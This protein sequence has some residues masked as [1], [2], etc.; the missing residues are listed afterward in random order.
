MCFWWYMLI[1]DLI[2]P[3]VMIISGRMMW[4]HCPNGS[5]YYFD[6]LD[7]SNRKS[8]EKNILMMMERVDNLPLVKEYFTHSKA[9]V[10]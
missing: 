10:K 6:C 4:K 5:M 7:L 1:C 8:F 3:I 9:P 2:I